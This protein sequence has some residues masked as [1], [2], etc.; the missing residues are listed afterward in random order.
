MCSDGDDRPPMEALSGRLNG[1]TQ[2]LQV[3]ELRSSNSYSS[4]ELG[5]GSSFTLVKGVLLSIIIFVIFW[6]TRVKVCIVAPIITI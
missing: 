2:T 3:L 5:N 4:F 1:M 6:T